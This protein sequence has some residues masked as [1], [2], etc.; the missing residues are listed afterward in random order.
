[1]NLSKKIMPA[2]VWHDATGPPAQADLEGYNPFNFLSRGIKVLKDETR[3]GGNAPKLKKKKTLAQVVVLPQ[4]EKAKKYLIHN[5]VQIED[6]ARNYYDEDADVDVIDSLHSLCALAIAFQ[7]F[8]EQNYIEPEDDVVIPLKAAPQKLLTRTTQMSTNVNG[9]IKFLF[10][11][12]VFHTPPQDVIARAPHLDKCLYLLQNSSFWML[13]LIENVW[14]RNKEFLNKY[15]APARTWRIGDDTPGDTNCWFFNRDDTYINHTKNEESYASV[16]FLTEI[17]N[18]TADKCDMLLQKL[19][20]RNPVEQDEGTKRRFLD[21]DMYNFIQNIESLDDELKILRDVYTS[22][23]DKLSQ[24]VEDEKQRRK[25]ERRE[26]ERQRRDQDLKQ[27]CLKGL[28]YWWVTTNQLCRAC[29]ILIFIDLCKFLDEYKLKLDEKVGYRPSLFDR[30]GL[31]TKTDL[32]GVYE[33]GHSNDEKEHYDSIEINEQNIQRAFKMYNKVLYGNNE[34]RSDSFLLR[35]WS[36]SVELCGPLFNLAEKGIDVSKRTWKFPATSQIEFKKKHW[37]PPLKY[38]EVALEKAYERSIQV[39]MSELA[40]DDRKLEQRFIEYAEC[41]FMELLTYCELTKYVKPK[42]DAKKTQQLEEQQ[43]KQLEE[44]Q[45]KNARQLQ[46]QRER[47][48]EQK[49]VEMRKEILGGILFNKLWRNAAILGTNTGHFMQKQVDY[50]FYAEERFGAMITPNS[51]KNAVGRV[52]YLCSYIWGEKWDNGDFEDANRSNTAESPYHRAN[53]NAPRG[54]RISKETRK[55]IRYVVQ[56]I[57]DKTTKL[58]DRILFKQSKANVEA[59]NEKNPTED[60]RTIAGTQLQDTAESDNAPSKAAD[61]IGLFDGGGVD[62]LHITGVELLLRVLKH[63]DDKDYHWLTAIK[64]IPQNNLITEII[65]LAANTGPESFVCR[66]YKKAEEK[67]TTKEL[68]RVLKKQESLPDAKSVIKFIED[69]KGDFKLICGTTTSIEKV[70]FFEDAVNSG[71]DTLAELIKKNLDACAELLF[72][73]YIDAGGMHPSRHDDRRIKAVFVEGLKEMKGGDNWADLGENIQAVL[74]FIGKGFDLW[75]PELK[76][77]A[78]KALQEHDNHFPSEA[79]IESHI[80]R[81]EHRSVLFLKSAFYP[82]SESKLKRHIWKTVFCEFMYGELPEK[83]ALSLGIT[84][85]G[86]YTVDD[87]QDVM[88]KKQVPCDTLGT[89]LPV[90]KLAYEKLESSL[91]GNFKL[92]Y[93]QIIKEWEGFFGPPR[94]EEGGKARLGTILSQ[95]KSMKLNEKCRFSNDETAFLE[96]DWHKLKWFETK[97]NLWGP[98]LLKLYGA[99]GGKQYDD[100]VTRSFLIPGQTEESLNEPARNAILSFVGRTLQFWSID[101]ESKPRRFAEARTVEQFYQM[102]ID[103]DRTALPARLYGG[104]LSFLS[105]YEFMNSYDSLFQRRREEQETLLKN[106]D[107]PDAKEAQKTLE[108]LKQELLAQPPWIQQDL[109]TV[110]KLKNLQ[111]ITYLDELLNKMVPDDDD[112]MAANYREDAKEIKVDDTASPEEIKEIVKP[113]AA[114]FFPEKSDEAGELVLSAIDAY[115]KAKMIKSDIGSQILNEESVIQLRCDFKSHFPE[116]YMETLLN[117]DLTALLNTSGGDSD[118]ESSGAAA[119]SG[120]TKN[121]DRS[122]MD[123]SESDEGAQSGDENSDSSAMDDSEFDEG[124]PSSDSDSSDMDVSESGD[125][126]K[127]TQSNLTA[128]SKNDEYAVTWLSSSSDEDES[129]ND[130]PVPAEG[131]SNDVVPSDKDAS[132]NNDDAPVAAAEYSNDVVLSNE[133]ES[134]NDDDTPVAGELKTFKDATKQLINKLLLKCKESQDLKLLKQVTNLSAFDLAEQSL[135]AQFGDNWYETCSLILARGAANLDLYYTGAQEGTPFENAPSQRLILAW[136]Q[137]DLRDETM[138]P[139]KALIEKEIREIKLQHKFSDSPDDSDL[140]FGG[141]RGGLSY[142]H[143]VFI[144]KLQ[145]S[146]LRTLAGFQPTT[147]LVSPNHGEA[148]KVFNFLKNACTPSTDTVIE[149]MTRV[150]VAQNGRNLKQINFDLVSDDSFMSRDDIQSEISEI[151]Q[152]QERASPSTEKRI[153]DL[154]HMMQK[155]PTVFENAKHIVDSQLVGYYTDADCTLEF[156][157]AIGQFIKLNVLLSEAQIVVNILSGQG[158]F[159]E[160]TIHEQ[161]INHFVQGDIS[162]DDIRAVKEVVEDILKLYRDCLRLNYSI[163]PTSFLRYVAQLKAL[164]KEG[165]TGDVIVESDDDE[166]V[167]VEPEHD[168]FDVMGTKYMLTNIKENES[169]VSLSP[170]S[171]IIPASAVGADSKHN[172]ISISFQPTS[173]SVIYY[174]DGRTLFDLFFDGLNDLIDGCDQLCKAVKDEALEKKRALSLFNNKTGELLFEAFYRYLPVMRTE[175]SELLCLSF[176][177]EINDSESD[178]GARSGDENSDSSDMEVSEPDSEP[179]EGSRSGDENSDPPILNGLEWANR[180]FR[181]SYLPQSQKYAE[182]ERKNT[183]QKEM[184]HA[185]MAQAREVE[186]IFESAKSSA[187]PTAD[188]QEKL[189]TYFLE[190]VGADNKDTLEKIIQGLIKKYE[191]NAN[192]VDQEEHYSAAKQLFDLMRRKQINDLRIQAQIVINILKKKEDFPGATKRDQLINH[193]MQ[194]EPSVDDIGETEEIVESILNKYHSLLQNNLP[195]NPDHFLLEMAYFNELIKR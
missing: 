90:V 115:Q 163:E 64:Q 182:Y 4:L 53:K 146:G 134:G 32:L 76:G 42:I 116:A 79:I 125:E 110:N 48:E 132:G 158:D 154:E 75:R 93:V 184:N 151:K 168:I 3:T 188:T 21:T 74:Y 131:Y 73:M 175:Y 104:A 138:L 13:D 92:I 108:S 167:D 180:V 10:V 165:E 36:D 190:R 130:T 69:T 133:D 176:D 49:Q 46:R 177:R 58:D 161:L 34:D 119:Q 124:A 60:E 120:D 100:H 183:D 98:I 164:T 126:M 94:A 194:K 56:T 39:M 102:L 95:A 166:P 83:K 40:C 136:H 173:T 193:F 114:V 155:R 129:D 118:Y 65:V 80:Q 85:P 148:F 15:G 135:I 68:R 169:S 150:I 189:Y 149:Y 142:P 20:T 91:H 140:L 159:P 24:V 179:D 123:D 99:A 139:G 27:Q 62:S 35:A 54:F 22:M 117:E 38:D 44:Q 105:A 81:L 170:F 192:F 55:R 52:G 8:N 17:Q 5:C 28:E 187:E 30:I 45:K 153:K 112:E 11:L 171:T 160:E 162:D 50:F 78:K 106:C 195:I 97:T 12:D 71:V 144:A 84:Q 1:M 70:V 101:G 25:Q 122:D 33:Y 174:A 86:S 41:V 31:G 113:L 43:K 111:R 61:L 157:D 59:L 19:A 14:M 29:R 63:A 145:S 26:Q 23:K 9:A 143:R 141:E 121:S 66:N 7:D 103:N 16:Q 51:T 172:Y 127:N 191:A 67:Y 137:C 18:Q 37:Y 72:K 107:V 152:L 57:S 178:E 89:Y 128:F 82:R 109:E 87:L 2:R 77:Q 185:E 156:P 186:R 88:L 147:K 47:D 181:E 6:G 96:S